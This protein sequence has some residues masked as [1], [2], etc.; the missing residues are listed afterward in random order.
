MNV[1]TS[2]KSVVE[3]GDPIRIFLAGGITDCADWQ[4]TVVSSF[5]ADKDFKDKNIILYNP[6]RE[7]WNMSMNS[8]AEAQRQ[9]E[10]EFKRLEKMDIFSMYFAASQTSV[11]PICLYELGRYVCRMQMRFPQDWQLRIVVDIENGYL[12]EN[13][14]IEQLYWA[15]R[16]QVCANT[17]VSEYTHAARIKKAVKRL[18]ELEDS[19]NLWSI[20]GCDDI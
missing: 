2:G 16:G 1:V 15:T 4:S 12:R 20:V 18:E 8:K 7:N 17:R 9:I 11:G 14:V 5:E 3:Y 13:D 19:P 6:R 10:W